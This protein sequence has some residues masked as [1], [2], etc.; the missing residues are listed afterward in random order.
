[1]LPPKKKQEEEYKEQELYH[2]CKRQF[3]DINAD[4]YFRRVQDHCPY[5]RKFRGA[6][7]SIYYLKYK[8]SKQIPVVF[9]NVCNYYYHLIIKKP[10]EEFNGQFKY[11][12]ENI[13]KYITLQIKKI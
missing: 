8:T 9:H 5:T 6:T 10:V 13:E 2:I 3:C 12:G 7:R 11:S 4:E 1:M